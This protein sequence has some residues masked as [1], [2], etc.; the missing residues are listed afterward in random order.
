MKNVLLRKVASSLLVV[1]LIPAYTWTGSNAATAADSLVQNSAVISP[2]IV[3]EPYTMLD[4]HLNINLNDLRFILDQIKIA[5]A[6]A[7]RT[8]VSVTPAI[9]TPTATFPVAFDDSTSTRCLQPEDILNANS[10]TYGLTGLSNTYTYSVLAPWGLREVNGECN[11]IAA[12][13]KSDWGSADK[14]FPRLAPRVETS[15]ATTAYTGL[16]APNAIQMQYANPSANVTDAQP[17]VV[18]N[19]ISDQS[20]ANTA[21][22]DAALRA[23]VL[24]DPAVTLQTLKTT[25]SINATTGAVNS[26]YEIPNITPDLNTS[27]GYN[28]W[29]TAFGQFFDHGLDLIP[30][31]GSKVTIPLAGTDPLYVAGQS[32]QM[33]LTRGACDSTVVPLPV[34]CVGVPTGESK[35][36]TSPYIDQSQTYGSVA[37]QNVL[38]REYSFTPSGPISTGMLLSSA[39]GGLPTWKDMKLQAAHLGFLLTDYDVESVPYFA[40]DQYGKFVPGPTGYPLMLFTDG[41]NYKYIEGNINS[42][43]PTSVSGWTAVPTGHAFIND[44][45]ATA[46]PFSRGAQL[47]PDSDTVVNSVLAPNMDQVGNFLSYDNESLDAHFI[48][49]D[50]RVNENIGLAAIHQTFHSE[51]N[52]VATD[53]EGLLSSLTTSNPEFLAEWKLPNNSAFNG[54]RIYQAARFVMESEYLHIV[55]DEFARRISPQLPAFA[56]TG[57]S[58]Q[59]NASI[60]A[61]FASAVYRVGHSMLNEDFPRVDPGTIYDPAGKNQSLSLIDA[62]TSPVQYQSVRPAGIASAS[63]AGGIYTYRLQ[64]GEPRSLLPQQGAVVSVR[65]LT[66]NSFN[67]ENLVVDSQDSQTPSF[68][69]STYYLGN[70]VAPVPTPILT[71]TVPTVTRAQSSVANVAPRTITYNLT[72]TAPATASTASFIKGQY[73]TINALTNPAFNLSNALIVNSTYLNST[74]S[75]ITVQVPAGVTNVPANTTINGASGNA[76]RVWTAVASSLASTNN[77]PIASVTITSNPSNTPAYSSD[78]AAAS[79]VGGMLG[80]R[81]NEIDEFVTDALRNNLLGQPLDLAA[82]NITRGRDVGLPTLNQ[83]RNYLT[84]HNI[85]SL[86]A[87][88]SWAAF[89]AALRNPESGANF[90]AA[91]GKS[92]STYNLSTGTIAA[93]RA[94]AAQLLL[95]AATV[96]TPA[97][98]FLNAVGGFTNQS[99]G[100]NDVDLWIGGLAENASVQPGLNQMFGPT[101]NYVFQDQMTRLQNGDRFY[102]LSRVAGMNLGEEIQT[103]K[104]NEMVKRN[105]QTSA[106]LASPSFNKTDCAYTGSLTTILN[107]VPISFRC[108]G[109]TVLPDGTVV[110]AGAD[111]VFGF[112]TPSLVESVT[113][114]SGDDTILGSTGNDFVSGGLAGADL[115]A[116]GDGN[117]I[118][119]GGPGEDILKGNY[120]NDVINAGDSIVGDLADGNAGS[121]FIHTGNQGANV[122]AS[123]ETG[124]DFL[125]GGIGPDTFIGGDGN[126]WIEGADAADI[127]DGDNGL[128]GGG[129]QLLTGGNDIVD[130]G[131]ANDLVAGGPGDDII[132]AG[133]GFDILDGG[134][135]FDWISYSHAVRPVWVDLSGLAPA[136]PALVDGAVD[137]EALSG[138][139]LDDVFYGSTMANIEIQN[140]SGNKGSL[141]MNLPAG[142]IRIEVGMFATGAGIA[143]HS[144]VVAISKD[145]KVVTLDAQLVSNVAGSVKF[146]SHPLNDLSMISGLSTLLAGAPGLNE[147]ITASGVITKKSVLGANKY[148]IYLFAGNDVIPVGASVDLKGSGAPVPATSL[149]ATVTSVNGRLIGLSFTTAPSD[150]AI[151]ANTYDAIFTPQNQFVGGNIMLGGA[152]NDAFHIYDGNNV[153]DGNAWLNVCLLVSG[154]ETGTDTSCGGGNGFNSMSPLAL[155][156]ETRKISPTDVQMVRE[157][158]ESSAADNDTVLYDGPRANYSSSIISTPDT[159]TALGNV[160][161][162]VRNLTTGSVDTLRNIE[163]I[164]WTDGACSFLSVPSNCQPIAQPDSPTVVTVS[165]HSATVR[166]TWDSVARSGQITPDRYIVSTNIGGPSCEIGGDSGTCTVNDLL[167]GTTYRFYAV[168][169]KDSPLKFISAASTLSAPITIADAISGGTTTPTVPSN[170][171]PGFGGGGAAA[172]ALKV[173]PVIE[174]NPVKTIKSSDS[175]S[176]ENILNAKVAKNPSAIPG[177]IVY[178]I[179]QGTKLPVGTSEVTATFIPDDQALYDVVTTSVFITVSQGQAQLTI[180]GTNFV[181]DGNPKGVVVTATP[182]D[183]RFVVTYNGSTE[184]PRNAGTYK[185]SALAQGSTTPVETTMVIAKATPSLSWSTN[186]KIST[187][188]SLGA[189]H[190]NAQS[191]VPGS[192][193]YSVTA[194]SKLSAGSHAV[195]ATFTPT[196]STNYSGAATEFVFSVTTAKVKKMTLGVTAQSGL[197]TSSQI[198]TLK[199]SMLNAETIVISR[200]V[201][202]TANKVADLAKSQTSLVALKRQIQA[203]MPSAVI[204]VKAMGS[205]TNTACRTTSNSCAQI[206]VVTP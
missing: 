145:L 91:Y 22:R 16:Y 168:A 98:N 166:I 170:P 92:F 69:A 10:Q 176:S 34:N 20:V 108:P 59:V 135:G 54:E 174:W 129:G 65:G 64:A 17:R 86:P 171:T 130:G 131:Q 78:R 12:S 77:A 104:F 182:S 70:T 163:T 158:K 74:A 199:A 100:L 45:T 198:S 121:D 111:N 103:Q 21:A 119:L 18:S 179:L 36:I 112:V 197:L 161:Y 96:G 183:T 195:T 125:Q 200:F 115:I 48:A 75:T 25:N 141:T 42:L 43:V 63:Y 89:I 144:Q 139:P 83:F 143:Q 205:K 52:T 110:H 147:T 24:L 180:S 23:Q 55:F 32:T 150:A 185:V 206:E 191:S 203:L 80:Q 82:L 1:A 204:S 81:G 14:V 105:S 11:N 15:S 33:T 193:T 196:D 27:A 73:V 137:V 4:G 99:T 39:D 44:M 5:E 172:P 134:S 165:G 114:G 9:T 153:I 167:S 175:V 157:I 68:T 152:G 155:P 186:G 120:G 67:L 188:L 138:S 8:A 61:E 57:Y 123:G 30:K 181:Y 13:S 29:F 122:I 148:Y 35:N 28:S 88:P 95:D 50:G 151:A 56:L 159:V 154:Y 117:D 184:A 124:D 84:T 146:T 93:R 62:F 192:F 189:A 79:V 187:N 97:Y 106:P 101:F 118:V 58:D 140:V 142:S 164:V 116:A 40:T 3:A 72:Y 87:Y 49:G 46:S 136:P 109:N 149:T 19:I 76:T 2:S 194:G 41:T 71:T 7:A 107:W 26:D 201:K 113:G 6:H 178:N 90:L 60:T 177:K 126:D 51:H 38:I 156:M 132:R 173:K 66:D 37:S 53:I 47:A 102:Y 128:N 190:L 133:N 169:I 162:Q 160:I 85:A 94:A 31:A 127:V 202:P